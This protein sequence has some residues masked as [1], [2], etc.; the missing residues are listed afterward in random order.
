MSRNDLAPRRFLPAPRGI[1]AP[2]GIPG[3]LRD[4]PKAAE[5]EPPTVDVE[6][7][8]RAACQAIG[9]PHPRDV[10]AERA[11]GLHHRLGTFRL[12]ESVAAVEAAVA[13]YRRFVPNAFYRFREYVHAAQSIGTLKS[14]RRRE[15]RDRE[16]Y[17]LALETGR[18]LLSPQP[19]LSALDNEFLDLFAAELHTPDLPGYLRYLAQR[20]PPLFD[21]LTR[22]L[23]AHMAEEDRG[24]HTYL[25]AT[26]KSG[27]TEF[28]KALLHSYVTKPRSAAIVVIDPAGDFARQIAHWPEF[29]ASDRLV[30]LDPTLAPGMMP[31]INP[32]EI[33]GVSPEDV[34]PEAVRT[35]EVIAQQII[36]A[37]KDVLE[38][39]DGSR[40]TTN[41]VTLLL[42]CIKVLLDRR[43]STLRDLQRFMDDETNEDLVAFGAAC[44]HYEGTAPFFQRRFRGKR[45][46]MSKGSIAGKLDQLFSI[47]TF[48]SLTCGPSTVDLRQLVEARKIIVFNLA[49]GEIGDMQSRA[50][51]RLVIALVQGMAKRR[52][53]IA[54][55][56]RVPTHLFIDE[57]HNFMSPTVREILL[58]Q[59]K[60]RLFLTLSQ[61]MVGEGMSAS[62]GDAITGSA[63]VL[64]SGIARRLHEAS[65][66]ALVGVDPR[67][68]RSLE[69]GEFYVSVGRREAYRLRTRSDLLGFSHRMTPPSWKRLVARQVRAYYRP[70]APERATTRSDPGQP[71]PPPRRKP[72]HD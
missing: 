69:K 46:E 21:I 24:E 13:V 34:S 4:V 16:R 31:T 65:A 42:N 6:A 45:L 2:R 51:G 66:A 52:A 26:T 59:R 50:L 11:R 62:L 25:V 33:S 61:Q 27:K 49:K 58:E 12:A 1:R 22:E 37:L 57:C 67:A 53:A 18:T 64:L 17:D 71:V 9:L 35:K 56:A 15:E 3:L 68:I 44:T 70:V 40:F 10:E 7:V 23:A 54:E 20:E 32:F 28:L 29:V 63:N 30:Y 60:Y 8:E 41:M 39:T 14:Q 19:L 5:P 72:R 38:D 55:H 43:G 48:L 36:E 47:N